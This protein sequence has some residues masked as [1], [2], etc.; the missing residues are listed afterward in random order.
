M[1]VK[2]IGLTV[3]AVVL[4]SLY[5]GCVAVGDRAAVA[6]EP[7]PQAQIRKQTVEVQAGVCS[8]SYTAGA[9]GKPIKGKL[10]VQ[11]PCTIFE[12]T[13]DELWVSDTKDA[14]SKKVLSAP[15]GL[16]TTE[17]SCRYCYINSSGGMSCIV[18]PSTC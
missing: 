16:F 18:M 17:G 14:G 3:A 10:T 8:W 7:P 9:D 15:K 2:L 5:Y 6:G 1:K 4:S 11:P 13:K 12:S